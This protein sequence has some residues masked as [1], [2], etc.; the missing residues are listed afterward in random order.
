[1][2]PLVFL[3]VAAAGGVGAAARYLLDTAVRRW[4]GERFPWGILVVNLTGALALGILSPLP[5]D[6][7]WRWI[8]GTGLLGGYTTFSAVAVTTAL[9]AEERRAHTATLYAVVSFVGSV[10]A[11]AI[12]LTASTLF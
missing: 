4:A 1:M 6:E 12:G 3:A 5:T 10:V 2:T 11:A 8:I 9:L 7:A